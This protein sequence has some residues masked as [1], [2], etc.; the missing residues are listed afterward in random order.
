MKLKFLKI[1]HDILFLYVMNSSNTLEKRKKIFLEKVKEKYGDIYKIDLENF[2]NKYSMLFII[3]NIH[4]VFTST[5][6][7]LLSKKGGCFM[8]KKDIL[9]NKFIEKCKQIKGCEDYDYS[10]II[11]NNT[12]T[13]VNIGCNIH[14]IFQKYPTIHSFGKGCPT[15]NK[16]LKKNPE[17]YTTE[18]F[19]ERATKIHDDKYDYS[20][21]KY[22][23]AKIKLII[24]CPIHDEFLQNPYQHLDG[25]GCP[26]CGFETTANKKRSNINEFIEKANQIHDNIYDYGKSI[27]INN[28]TY[29]IIIC[30]QHGEF[31]QTPSNHLFGYGCV[32]CGFK[33]TASKRTSNTI[34]FIEKA[35]SVHGDIY[36]YS[37][38]EY[39]KSIDLLTIICPTHGEFQQVAAYHLSGNGCQKCAKNIFSR[40]SNEWIEH[41]QDEN[42]IELQYI[43]SEDGE[44]C[45][46]K[47]KADGYHKE[48][49]TIYE[50]HGDFWHGNPKFYNPEDIHPL[51]KKEFG[52][53]MKKTIHKEMHLRRQG[54]NYVCIW[55]HEWNKIKNK[56]L[57]NK[58]KF[59]HCISS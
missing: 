38:S 51:N 24:I 9:K 13:K 40:V 23:N 57:Q 56:N 10:Q 12:K 8:C 3:C 26:T 4:G 21:S 58:K 5:V 52:M 7:H 53:L 31:Q 44:K 30:P 27:Y 2:L 33:N 17:K 1:V 54:Y 15:C 43:L 50:F 19:I 55:E 39:I 48:S 32:Y 41:I 14:G 11:Y 46:G 6:S 22:V 47:Y 34:S 20:K 59:S 25:H 37:L 16:T 42:N 35:K 36:D 49:K 45:I 29:L 28:S 18:L